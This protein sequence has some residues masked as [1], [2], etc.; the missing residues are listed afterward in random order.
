MPK[1]ES[2]TRKVGLNFR[3]IAVKIQGDAFENL[4]MSNFQNA[5][6]VGEDELNRNTAL[7]LKWRH[8]PVINDVTN[9]K[10]ISATGFESLVGR[11]QAG[12]RHIRIH[13]S[14]F[15]VVKMERL[16]PIS[17]AKPEGA[18]VP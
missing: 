4:F 6:V 7:S 2:I 12:R 11:E 5:H 13:G 8:P 3:G 9:P 16:P 1:H 10:D 18:V 17:L 15:Q 14:E